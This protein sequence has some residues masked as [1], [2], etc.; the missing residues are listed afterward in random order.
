MNIQYVRRDANATGR[1]RRQ[2]LTAMSGE[3]TVQRGYWRTTDSAGAE[4]GG[5]DVGDPRGGGEDLLDAVD[6]HGH[7]PGG[8]LPARG[9]DDELSERAELD[10]IASP[11]SRN[12][13]QLAAHELRG[14]TGIG[15]GDAACVLQLAAEALVSSAGLEP[16][17]EEHQ[18]AERD[19]DPRV[20]PPSVSPG[21]KPCGHVR[22]HGRRH[23][24][25][26]RRAGSRVEGCRF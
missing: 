9:H 13:P 1:G 15:L 12:A 16:A 26:S 21:P 6:L 17:R 11:S 25:R 23:R 7:R 10:G 2:S 20:D 8:L 14:G 19:E 3:P 4:A 24:C 5:L 22:R 18:H